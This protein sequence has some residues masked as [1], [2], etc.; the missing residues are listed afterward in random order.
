MVPIGQSIDAVSSKVIVDVRIGLNDVS[1]ATDRYVR[2]WAE[3][4]H[5]RC[6]VSTILYTPDRNAMKYPVMRRMFFDR[7]RPPGR[8]LMWFDD[9]SYLTHPDPAWWGRVRTACD[10]VSLVGAT[11]W[12]MPVR[13]RRGAWARHQAWSVDGSPPPPPGG[14][15][16][17]MTPCFQ[18]AAGGWWVLRRGVAWRFDYPFRGLR[19]CGGDTALGELIRQRRLPTRHFTG[20]VAINADADGRAFASARRGYREP[21]AGTDFDPNQPPD[22]SHQ[23]FECRREVISG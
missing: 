3:E 20:G 5:A 12:R 11:G 17:G 21:D 4:L 6:G 16:Y 14:G 23:Y 9:D 10:G 18:F 2:H 1:P 8:L 19:H 22:D 7:L 13:G 15:K